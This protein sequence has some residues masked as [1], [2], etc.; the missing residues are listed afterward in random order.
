M[1]RKSLTLAI[2]LCAFG[3]NTQAQTTRP[4]RAT[5]TQSTTPTTTTQ[6]TTT[7]TTVEPASPS[8]TRRARTTTTTTTTV[9]KSD[10]ATA[11]RAAFDKVLDGIR[12]SDIGEVMKVYTNSPQLIVFNNNGTTTRGANNYRSTREQIYAKATDV[13]LDVR[14]VNVTMLGRDGAI[15]SCLWTQ[16]Q[17]VNG[18]NEAATGRMT[19]A[20]ERVSGAWKAVHTHTS[21][22]APDPS[23]LMPSDRVT[24]SPS[25]ATSTPSTT[26]TEVVPGAQPAIRPATTAPARPATRP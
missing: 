6:S 15:V 25:P 2:A 22:D 24:S 3:S 5:T 17:T 7:T 9:A 21:P 16:E 12:A 1:L 11:V 13:R 20:F 19:I 26:T 10:A 18:V 8:R 4:S 23:R 14:D